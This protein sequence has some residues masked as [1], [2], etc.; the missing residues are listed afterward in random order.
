[1]LRITIHETPA[2]QRF[3]LEGKLIQPCVSELE[4][5]WE[6]TRNERQGRHCIVDLSGTIA[7]DPCGKKMLARMSGEGAHFIVTGVATKHLIEGIEQRRSENV[8][9]PND[10]RRQ[11]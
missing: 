5:A 7:I 4:S 3:V 2:E 9:E 11:R 10:P 1:M 8:S 6:R